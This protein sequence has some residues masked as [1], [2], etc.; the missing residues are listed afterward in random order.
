MLN[1]RSFLFIFIIIIVFSGCSKTINK[2]KSTNA[3]KKAG[4]EI[5][6]DFKP[7]IFIHGYSGTKNSL[8]GMISRLDKSS[9]NTHKSFVIEVNPMGELKISGNYKKD[10]INLIQ[11]IF[12]NNKASIELQSGWIQN[13]LKELYK[14]EI[15]KADIVAHSMG[16]EGTAYYLENIPSD[17]LTKIESF[18]PIGTPFTWNFGGPD[19]NTENL[20]TLIEKNIF[21]QNK[22]NLPAN[23]S[24]FAI[25]GIISPEE[26]TDGTVPLVSATFGKY[27]FDQVKY[28]EKIVEGEKARH[29]LLH[30][31]KEV[32]K[33]VAD[34][35]WN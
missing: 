31:N 18:I 26:K 7:V 30:E 21:V 12:A 35:L 3:N 2:A 22:D 8:K 11:V 10:K 9:K 1:R 23:L 27:I 32:D 5:I 19:E 24:V 6:R 4:N 28:K 20:D 34:F 17:D 14:R 13:V 29:K 25:A 15:K 33:L 16:G